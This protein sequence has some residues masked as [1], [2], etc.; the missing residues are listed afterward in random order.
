MRRATPV[1]DQA[2]A[3]DAGA[4]A[5]AARVAEPQLV[6]RAGAGRSC[7]SSQRAQCAQAAE[8]TAMPTAAA[9]M[10][11]TADARRGAASVEPAVTG[12]GVVVGAGVVAEPVVVAGLNVTPLSSVHPF[13]FISLITSSISAEVISQTAVII[14]LML[15]H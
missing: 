5:G 1:D 3:F 7:A 11:A 2:S 13:P 6:G 14:S 12:A 9:N 10:R 15:L 8:M 4:V